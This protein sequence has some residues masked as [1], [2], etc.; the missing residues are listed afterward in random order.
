MDCVPSSVQCLLRRTPFPT[1]APV[2]IVVLADGHR[3]HL[4]WSVPLYA[5]IL[6]LD[7]VGALQR[8]AVVTDRTLAADLGDDAYRRLAQESEE[9]TAV[10]CA[11][12]AFRS[13][14]RRLSVIAQRQPSHYGT[15]VQ[16]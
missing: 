10:L 6:S 11:Q 16:V 4:T 5:A 1:D 7:P 12:P 2:L 15:A 3:M 9:H 8:L 13:L 14:A